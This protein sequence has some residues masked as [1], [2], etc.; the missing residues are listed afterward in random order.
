MD[1]S[2]EILLAGIKKNNRRD[3]DQLFIKYYEALCRYS[4]KFIM[5]I[6]ACEDIVQAIFIK[7][8]DKRKSINI[9]SS[10]KSYLYTS[11]RNACFD[12]IKR[13][14]NYDMHELDVAENVSIPDFSNNNY[15]YKI[16][17][18]NI[19]QSIENLP[20]KCKI[21]FELS[22]YSKLSYAEISEELGISKKTIENQINIALKRIR[23]NISNLNITTLLFFIQKKLFFRG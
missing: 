3:L 14:V 2:D 11:V 8:W 16:L 13:E 5:D 9:N 12:Y 1:L 19:A 10:L 22:R 6:N 18:D 7:F 4:N 21:I 17:E 23:K 20:K 15:D